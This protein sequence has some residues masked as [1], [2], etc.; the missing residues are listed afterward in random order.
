[1][2][3]IVVVAAF[4]AAIPSTVVGQFDFISQAIKN[5]ESVSLFYL[6]GGFAPKSTELTTGTPGKAVR[7]S[8]LRG[9]GFEVSIGLATVTRSEASEKAD[10]EGSEGQAST[11]PPVDTVEVIDVVRRGSGA[12]V[13]RTRPKSPA[14]P[15]VGETIWSLQLA[16]G[17]SQTRGFPSRSASHWRNAW[18][19]T[20]STSSLGV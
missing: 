7:Q 19:T 8:D 11:K 6:L 1:M 18:S 5:I 2:R 15:E 13:T 17:Y 9:F 12:T 14:S 10:A 16:I 20:R 3:E 4:F